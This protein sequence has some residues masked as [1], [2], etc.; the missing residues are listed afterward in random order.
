MAKKVEKK[1]PIEDE[2]IYEAL[3][4]AH[5]KEMK[6]HNRIQS[7]AM[8]HGASYPVDVMAS[9][10]ASLPYAKTDEQKQHLLE[11]LTSGNHKRDGKI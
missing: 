7:G 3:Q 11:V 2:E 5:E 10:E 9:Y 6:L 1:H 8:D 4:E